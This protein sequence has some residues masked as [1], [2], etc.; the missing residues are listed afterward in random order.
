MKILFSSYQSISLMKGGPTYKIKC[1]KENLENLSVDVDLFDPWNNNSINSY[2]LV[3]IFNAHSG[4]YHF[5]VNFICY[6]LSIDVTH[7]RHK[8]KRRLD[9]VVFSIVPIF[10]V[11]RG[12]IN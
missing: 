11:V 6:I 12:Q 10:H 5:A 3:H 8:T 1:L 7:K 9:D 4:V 2:D